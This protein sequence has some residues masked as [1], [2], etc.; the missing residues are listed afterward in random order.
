MTDKKIIPV[1]I[2]TLGKGLQEVRIV[3]LFKDVGDS[4][5]KDEALFS[6]ETDK[7]AVDVESIYTGK[8]VKW[9]AEED[10]IL[11]VRDIICEMEVDAEVEEKHIARAPGQ[12]AVSLSGKTVKEKEKPQTGGVFVVPK[13]R[14]YCRELG[15]DANEMATIPALG[16]RL[17]CADV[18]R[19]MET[20]GQSAQSAPAE[21][22]PAASRIP[23]PDG[24]DIPLPRQQQVLNFRFRQSMSQVIPSTIFSEINID[25]LGQLSKKLLEKEGEDPNKLFV[26]DF[27]FFAHV[28]AQ[29]IGR[30]PKFRSVLIDDR[31]RRQFEHLN[32]G[33]A[34]SQGEDLLTAVVEEAE[35]LSF[36]GFIKTMQDRIDKVFA[37]EDQAN[38]MPHFLITYMGNSGVLAGVPLLPAPAGG[39]LAFGS[40]QKREGRKTAWLSL[41]FD[42][43]LVN[44]MEAAQFL[45]MIGDD[46]EKIRET[47]A[48]SVASTTPAQAPAAAQPQSGMQRE[49]FQRFAVQRVAELL[50]ISTFEVS[51]TESLGVL[52]LNSIMGLKLKTSLEEK[53]GSELPATLIWRHPNL[54]SIVQYCHDTYGF[55]STQAVTQTAPAVP[56]ENAADHDLDA[57]MR[58]M[59]GLSEDEINS[60][61]Q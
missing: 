58:A 57:L 33:L 2:P 21:S 13:A 6:V 40:P 35:I 54:E 27:A 34:V 32:L 45:Q 4:V 56:G 28:V 48:Q 30:F 16:K 59:E 50:D 53:L 8:L 22:A 1:K 42:H 31:N 47:A 51:T 60:L 19:Y 44:G 24:Q 41:T 38:A 37:G 7:S 9:M 20:R 43:R 10:D 25:G 36:G 49:A 14:A 23:L 29:V 15:I 46:I 26:S 18:D 11:H 55:A 3:A 61:L 17:K 52:G 12:G 5:E 39:I